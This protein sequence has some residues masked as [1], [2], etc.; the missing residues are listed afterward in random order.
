MSTT[1]RPATSITT[2]IV[3]LSYANL[4][5]PTSM[6]E[7]QKKKYN[8]AILIDKTDKTTVAR[9]KTAIAAAEVLGKEKF[10]KS[11]IPAKMKPCLRDGDAEKPEDENY[12]GHYFL[13][14]KSTTQPIMVNRKGHVIVDHDEIYSGVYAYVSLNFYPYNNVS[15]G[16]GVGLG[17]IMKAKDGEAFSGR[18]TPDED[19]AELLENAGEDDDLV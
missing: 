11:W 9:V 3:R 15:I 7:N 6:D 18:S 14:A 10:G 19:F 1:Q 16:V 13:N 8:T 5:E 17:N 2:G 12:A 4:W